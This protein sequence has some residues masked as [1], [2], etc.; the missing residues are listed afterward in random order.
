MGDEVKKRRKRIAE[1]ST[2]GGVANEMKNIYRRVRHGDME[3]ALG[4]T[5]V[6]ILGDI[7]VCIESS[8]IE[9]RL[10][11]IESY[12]RASNPLSIPGNRNVLRRVFFFHR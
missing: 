12:V 8:D 2:V 11:S 10:E 6:G 3:P 9:R 7:G 1:L 5:L 4:K